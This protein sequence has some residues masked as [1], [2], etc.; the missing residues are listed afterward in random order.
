M[1]EIPEEAL[2][3]ASKAV[4]AKEW[5]A[6]APWSVHNIHQYDSDCAVCQEDVPAMVAVAL[7]AAAPILAEHIAQQ[8]ERAPKPRV[9]HR[10]W[11]VRIARETFPPTKE[12][13]P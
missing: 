4:M 13:Q 1:P 7:E 8:I 9:W 6:D 12:Q 11:A 10:A 5:K 2:R 3:A